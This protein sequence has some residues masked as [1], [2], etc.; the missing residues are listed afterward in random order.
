MVQVAHSRNRQ[1]QNAQRPQRRESRKV[2][3]RKVHGRPVN[4]LCRCSV[5]AEGLII[6]QPNTITELAVRAQDEKLARG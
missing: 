1:T 2:E 5:L 3:S 4:K 6:C